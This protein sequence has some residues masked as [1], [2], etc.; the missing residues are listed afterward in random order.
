VGSSADVSAGNFNNATA[1]GYGAVVNASNK[2]R[3][4]NSAVTVVETA[5]QVVAGGG[6][7]GDGSKLTGVAASGLAAGTYPNAYTFSNGGNS[8]TGSSFTGGSFVGTSLNVGGSG[9]VGGNLG[10][11]TAVPAHKAEL[12]DASNTGLRVQTNATGGTVASFGGNGAFQIEAPGIVGGRF[13]VSENGNIGVGTAS[14]AAKLDVAGSVRI[15]GDTPMSSNPRMSFSAIFLGSLCSGQPPCGGFDGWYAGGFVPDKNILIT[16]MILTTPFQQTEIDPSCL[17]GNAYVFGFGMT[18]PIVK[19]PLVANSG[20][21]DSGPLAG[22]A[23]A[24]TQLYFAMW[25][26]DPNRCKVGAS[27]GG[28][29]FINVE[30]VMQ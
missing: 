22:S 20:F 11:G 2:I 6:F 1:I 21:I 3:L 12:I 28:N 19:V 8:F 17:P 10:V 30:Y 15:G 27:A 29:F 24:G 5:G 26:D 14:P 9:I 13:T 18:N 7:S 25:L 23:P 16:R 4:G